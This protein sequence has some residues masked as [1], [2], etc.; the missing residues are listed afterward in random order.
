M[1]IVL[2]P[3]SQEA[4]EVPADMRAHSTKGKSHDRGKNTAEKL[5][6]VT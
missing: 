2:P 6:I 5:K 3:Q 1:S 4:A